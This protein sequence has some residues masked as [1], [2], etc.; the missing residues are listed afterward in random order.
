MKAPSVLILL[1]VSAVP[2]LAGLMA[3]LW[4]GLDLD[5]LIRVL[6]T[7]GIG[8]SI[9]SSVWTGVIATVLSL[10]LAHLAVAIAVT[11]GWRTRLNNFAL[12]LL[13]MPHLAIGI[14]LALVLAPSG[15]LLRL[16]SPWATG[17]TQ[18]PDWLSV[19]DPMGLSLIA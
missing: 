16:T 15:L 11:G 17:F 18:P 6:D 1:A 19:Q 8:L 4:S 3:A 2:T 5:S 10:L 9:A 7:P 13:A 12:P 14:G